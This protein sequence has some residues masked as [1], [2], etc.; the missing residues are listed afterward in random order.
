[1]GLKLNGTHQ[2]RPCADYVNLLEDNVLTINRNID[3]LI[4]TSKVVV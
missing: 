2:L 4:T 1:V 3:T